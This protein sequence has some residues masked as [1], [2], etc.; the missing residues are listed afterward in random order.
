MDGSL[1]IGRLFGIPILLH[2][3]FLLIIPLL[4]YIIGSEIDDTSQMLHQ[5]FNI[6][7]DTSIISAGYT[8]WI[9]GAIV[10]LGL[11]FGVLVHEL[12]HSLVARSK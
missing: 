5:I 2:W 7:I 11:F 12:A 4:A 1:R 9:L 6:G 10:A 3:T 8:P